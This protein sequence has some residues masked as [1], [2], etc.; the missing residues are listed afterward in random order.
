MGTF[1]LIINNN[2]DDVN[3]GRQTP[4]KGINK[5]NLYVKENFQTIKIANPHL[6]TPQVMKKLSQNYKQ[7]NRQQH[8]DLPELDKLTI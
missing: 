5:Y 7:K 4:K 6:S 8:I 2:N 1:D 3:R